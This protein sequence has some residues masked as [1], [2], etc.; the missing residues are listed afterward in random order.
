[1]KGKKT[2]RLYVLTGS[3]VVFLSSLSDSDTTK[4]WHMRL[5]HMSKRALSVLS[6]KGL[7]CGQS[8]GQMKSVSI[9]F[10]GSRREYASV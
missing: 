5:Y 4:L 7:L 10:L 9:V 3:A 6:K 2:E 1:M 8:T